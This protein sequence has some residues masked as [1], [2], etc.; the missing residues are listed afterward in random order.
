MDEAR[1]E[2]YTLLANFHITNQI[3]I[4]SSVDLAKAFDTA[5]HDVLM[6]FESGIFAKLPN[7]KKQ[8]VSINGVSSAE[9]KSNITPYFPRARCPSGLLYKQHLRLM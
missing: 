8:V 1:L 3:L 5:N 6:E 4:K 7:N 2:L 9:R